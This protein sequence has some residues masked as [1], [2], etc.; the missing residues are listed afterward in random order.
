LSGPPTSLTQ[1]RRI[2]WLGRVTAIRLAGVDIREAAVE[3]LDIV[4]RLRLRFLAE[5]R[6]VDPSELSAG[7]VAATRSFLDRHFEAKTSRSWVASEQGVD[8]GVVTMLILDLAP[9]PDDA[10]GLEGYVVNMY[11]DRAHRRRGVGKALLGE[12]LNA[13]GEIGMRRLLLHATD[14]GRS[15]YT[16]VGFAANPN[17][18][19]LAL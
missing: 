16:S 13:A 7:F 1:R 14:D 3:D 8:I 6:R 5:H 9:R 10:T 17:W 11:V 15:L 19:E 4:T 2:H 18:M 12:C